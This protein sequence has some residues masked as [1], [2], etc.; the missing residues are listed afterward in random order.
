MYRRRCW[1]V[2][3]LLILNI[4][5]LNT[6]FAEENR[7]IWTTLSLKNRAWALRMDLK[8]FSINR[9]IEEQNQAFLNA[10][11][12]T[13]T[14]EVYL[15]LTAAEDPSLTLQDFAK[16]RWDR[17]RL[18]VKG[19][20]D[21]IQFTQD[22]Q[23]V[24]VTYSMLLSGDD[25]ITKGFVVFER[26]DNVWITA[27]VEKYQYRT[28]HQ[29]Y[30]ED[31]IN[32]IEVIKFYRGAEDSEEAQSLRLALQNLSVTDVSGAETN[33]RRV[34]E[35]NS[36]NG[37]AWMLLGNLYAESNRLDEANKAFTKALDQEMKSQ[38]LIP[39]L[40]KELISQLA[41]NEDKLG[42]EKQAELV[43]QKGIQLNPESPGCYYEYA[44]FLAGKGKA[45]KAIEVLDQA[46]RKA[47][48][49]PG[50][51]LSR[52]DGEP[53]FQRLKSNPKFQELIKKFDSL[54]QA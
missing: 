3:G 15:E 51:K 30:V 24:T 47:L 12:I 6:A 43:Y 41:A 27:R 38:F 31:L 28:A 11:S 23:T 34:V 32:T 4:G 49:Y 33:L 22:N 50:E 52:P 16:L 10:R 14:T 37:F 21:N 17:M 25:R 1:L 42:H 9:H 40:Q 35:I 45:D 18:E 46:C 48:F 19:Y 39:Q 2:L 26:F 29:K 53:A 5:L 13:Q 54:F 44:K 20:P 7:P 8:G 36:L